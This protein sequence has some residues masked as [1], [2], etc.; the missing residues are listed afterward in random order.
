MPYKILVVDDEPVIT[1]LLYDHLSDN[2]YLVYTAQNAN[3]AME[4]L[5]YTPDLILL[6]IN[7]PG[8]DGLELCRMIRQTVSCP[9]L[10]LTARITEQDKINGLRCGG[11]DYITKPFS[12]GEIT[13]RIEAHLRREE[14][15]RSSAEVVS[16]SGL[17]VNLSARTVQ[18]QGEEIPFPKK[19][20]DILEYLLTHAGQTFD[21]ERIYEAVWGYD[22]EGDS[23]V[24]KEHIRRIRTRLKE[25]TGKEYVETVWG[26]GY[27]WRK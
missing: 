1:E 3:S 9:I 5:K 25:A 12:L 24:V 17:L 20:F 6:D 7:M 14:R 15:S 16:S 10:F 19:E 2:G 13:A 4:Q 23:D 8:T 22:A 11:D 21:R 18:Y 27:K 26:M